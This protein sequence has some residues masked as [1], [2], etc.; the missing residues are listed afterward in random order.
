[1]LLQIVFMLFTRVKSMMGGKRDPSMEPKTT[2]EHLLV[3]ARDQRISMLSAFSNSAFYNA[4]SS[5]DCH[6]AI[7][8]D[9]VT[10]FIF[11]YLV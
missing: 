2:G 5:Q 1:M 9:M 6:V 4:P 10:W 3:R 11:S 7:D 8:C